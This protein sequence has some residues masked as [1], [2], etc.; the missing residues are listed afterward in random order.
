METDLWVIGGG[1]VSRSR[2]EHRSRVVTSSPFKRFRARIALLQI[3]TGWLL[4]PVNLDLYGAKE[5]TKEPFRYHLNAHYRMVSF[6][7]LQKEELP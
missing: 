7:I 5:K 2:C 4:D 3:V 1:H 6:R